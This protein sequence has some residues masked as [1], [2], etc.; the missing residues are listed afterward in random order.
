MPGQS[1]WRWKGFP[2]AILTTLS[3][4][5][6]LP[7][8]RRTANPW[9]DSGRFASTGVDRSTNAHNAASAHNREDKLGY[10]TEAN[11]DVS[12]SLTAAEEE[13]R[14][15]QKHFGRIDLLLFLICTLVGLDTIGTVANIG[16]QGLTW[17]V[18][19]G[20]TFFVPYAL[21][22]AELGSTFPEE[23]G[24]YIWTRM[25]FG[26]LFAAVTSMFYWASN[27]I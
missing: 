26:R 2:Y 19:L 22:T 12:G 10:G 9:K 24:T 1:I 8:A 6:R 13:R 7:I 25:A 3:P 15:L 4:A 11:Q 16:A 17:L 27:P 23:G 5:K 14:K 18:F 20:L 21:L